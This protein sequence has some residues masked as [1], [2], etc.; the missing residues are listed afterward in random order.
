VKAGHYPFEENQ[1]KQL[2]LQ[3]LMDHIVEGELEQTDSDELLTI[4]GNYRAQ[5]FQLKLTTYHKVE[6]LATAMECSQVEIV[7]RA[8]QMYAEHLESEK[9]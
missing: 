1:F 2:T 7:E 8:I 6:E 9:N 3:W 4:Y 5:T